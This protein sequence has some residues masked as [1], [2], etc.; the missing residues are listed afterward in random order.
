[1]NINGINNGGDTEKITRDYFDSLLVE[2]R[3]IDAV[4]PST[5]LELYGETF[6]TPVM[7]AA[8]SHLNKVHP[9]G[10][11]EAARGIVAANG[12]MW[13][14]MG[15]EAELEAICATG[16]KTIKI[17]KPYSDNRDIFRKI[18]HAEKYGCIAVGIDIDHQFGSKSCRGS[19][20]N[21]PVKPK[22]LKEIE[23]FV[24]S[25]QLPFIIKGVLSTVD[26]QKCLD[27]GV[28]G[29]V[30]SHHHGMVDYAVPPLQIL[31][32]IV[33][34]IKQ[35]IPIFVDCCVSRGM[36]AFKALALGATAV[37]VG[38]ALMEVLRTSGW[39][40]VCA[41]IE[42]MTNELNWAM[43]VTCSPDITHIDPRII[44]KK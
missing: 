42:E 35:Q 8:L 36:D 13:A 26:A 21:L 23:S 43:A 30:V 1:M 3:H 20:L 22:S 12:V 34:V 11:V 4:E 44:V 38:R 9:E 17:I 7:M 31:P 2:M 14:G 33:T 29:I 39:H 16:A 41:F 5:K 32:A 24:K 27:A 19:V 40:G 37:S 15:D 18:E 28:R 25:T 6:N 10:M